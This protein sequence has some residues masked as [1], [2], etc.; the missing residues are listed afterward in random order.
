MSFSVFDT[1]AVEVLRGP[2]G[3]LFGR[4][5][6]GG[7][8]T[9]R[10]HKPTFT[11]EGFIDV[12]YG[13]YRHFVAEGAVGGPITDKL[14]V[15]IAFVKDNQSEGYF[16][17]TFT[18]KT[19]GKVD[20]FAV[21][22]SLL[23]KPAEDWEVLGSI[24]GGYDNSEP[25]PFD[26]VGTYSRSSF[27]ADAR[28]PGGG[29]YGGV[30]RN[31]FCATALTG[32]ADQIQADPNCVDRSGY[33]DA[34]SDPFTTTSN[35]NS[36]FNNR[37]LGGV[38]R[39][40]KDFDNFQV[41]S[42]S[43]YDHFD[44]DQ[45]EDFDG[46]RNKLAGVK[47][48]SVIKNFTQELRALSTGHGPFTWIVGGYY[49]HDSNKTRDV[50]DTDFRFLG[51]LAVIYDQ[52]TSTYAGFGQ[53][54]YELT[55]QIKFIAGG[56][57]THE[58][59]SFDGHQDFI[60]SADVTGGRTGDVFGLVPVEG[61]SPMIGFT[62]GPIA[63][64]SSISNTKFTWK[65]GIDWK[66]TPDL[67]I[68][69]NTSRG[70]KSGGFSGFFAT[71][72]REF[73]PFGAETIQ[74]YEAGFK[75]K[76]FDGKLHFSGAGY[77]YDYT[78]MQA[79]GFNVNTFVFTIDNLPKVRVN[80]AEFDVKWKVAKGLD[81]ISGLGWINEAKVVRSVGGF[82]I[83]LDGNRLPDSPKVTFTTTGRYEFDLSNS[84]S[85]ATMLTASYKSDTNHQIENRP[86][87]SE[88]AYWLI[89][90]RMTL[91][92]SGAN[93][94]VSLWAKNLANKRYFTETFFAGNAGLSSRLAGAPRTF[95]ISGRLSY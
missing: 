54:S 38:L 68:Y 7:A 90:G 42:V 88:P 27:V 67:L 79:L 10:A 58:K 12:N 82:S 92:K 84:L 94:E 44:R 17:N 19:D 61:T 5:T 21:R 32:S 14:A 69:A 6:T 95:G 28:Y 87:T 24:H 70:V 43:G 8:V 64:N 57:V 86:A 47:Y 49:S 66:P 62:G 41:V 71:I 77:Y 37:G 60:N 76:A 53:I 11:P 23:W 34:D 40:Q 81:L 22:G 18:G 85:L 91:A 1:E 31:Q 15:R 55:D 48:D 72:P 13:N 29:Y 63:L 93:W 35:V 78:N 56:R 39:I 26:A 73:G 20:K 36:R 65:V 4:N 51:D 74:S 52:R 9:F 50:F 75:A 2:Q 89:D 16:R 59:T 30:G 46:N 80:G 25:W 45:I 83:P 33:H 3:T